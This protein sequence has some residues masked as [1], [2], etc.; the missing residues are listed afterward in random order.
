MTERKKL[1]GQNTAEVVDTERP[2][3]D[4]VIVTRRRSLL[5]R[6]GCGAALLIWLVVM[7][8]P[9]A[10]FVLA[11]EGTIFIAHPG[12]VPSSHEHPLLRVNLIMEIDFRGVSLTHSSLEYSGGHDLCIQTD[13]RYVLWQGEGEPAS[14]CDCYTREGEDAPWE[15]VSRTMDVCD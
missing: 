8:L 6:I 10:L 7:L 1:P 4:Y 5:R 14:F 2:E 12:D 3:V 13:V 11:I 9:L 15:M